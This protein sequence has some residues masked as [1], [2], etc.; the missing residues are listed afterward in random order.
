MESHPA[1]PE[2]VDMR[3]V[4]QESAYASKIKY[5]FR[6]WCG[7]L[8]QSGLDGCPVCQTIHEPEATKI[9]HRS[10]LPRRERQLYC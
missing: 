5:C 7:A 9:H 3:N 4:G 8:K 10:D 2:Y 1:S 6:V